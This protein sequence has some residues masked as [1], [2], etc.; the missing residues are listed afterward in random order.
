[1]KKKR[2]RLRDFLELPSERVETKDFYNNSR[3]IFLGTYQPYDRNNKAWYGVNFPVEFNWLVESLAGSMK[4]KLIQTMLP[5]FYAHDYYICIHEAKGCD[6]TMALDKV[7]NVNNFA[8]IKIYS[9]MY[10]F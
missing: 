4:S 6:Y 5:F 3:A 9:F 7:H 2:N 10:L 1:M 8:I